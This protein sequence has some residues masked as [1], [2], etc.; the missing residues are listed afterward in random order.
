MCLTQA[1]WRYDDDE[2]VQHNTQHREHNPL[3]LLQVL[4]L[5]GL[6]Y[7]DTAAGATT[8]TQEDTALTFPGEV[9]RI[10]KSIPGD[11]VVRWCFL[12]G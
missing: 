7:E 2:V 1:P 12:C 8:H 5:Q 9:D 11:I 4:G 10:Y 6:T 3:C